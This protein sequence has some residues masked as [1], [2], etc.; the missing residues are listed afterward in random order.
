[1]ETHEFRTLGFVASKSPNSVTL[2]SYTY[3]DVEKSK[4]GVRYYRL[5]QVDLD[6]KET[7]FGPRTVSFDGKVSEGQGA[8]MTAY[9][10]PFN[11]A[12]QLHLTLQ[13]AQN[14]NASLTIVDMTG[15]IVRQ[16]KV[17]VLAG[18]NDVTV[19]HIND[20]KSGLYQVRFV[21]PTGEV[22]NLKVMKQ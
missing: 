20:L 22:R 19:D 7:F 2:Q 12:D 9:P 15:R 3:V 13:S 16:Q 17:G 18:S 14:G 11:S 5:R 1:M 8:V 21:L 6:G 10:N 4:A